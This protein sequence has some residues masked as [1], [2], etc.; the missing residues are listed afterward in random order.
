MVILPITYSERNCQ[1]KNAVGSAQSI[2]LQ[3]K[4]SLSVDHI[5]TVL[6]VMSE[7]QKAQKG[8]E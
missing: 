2:A 4:A 5:D 1:I 3:H 8:G 6:E 7:W